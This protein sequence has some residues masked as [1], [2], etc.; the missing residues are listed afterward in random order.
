MRERSR[1]MV[2]DSL[3]ATTCAGWRNRVLETGKRPT[4][5]IPES[6]GKYGRYGV[7]AID[8]V[9]GPAVC[10]SACRELGRFAEPRSGHDSCQ[11]V[12]CR[13]VEPFFERFPS[14][15]AARQLGGHQF[16]ARCVNPRSSFAP[17]TFADFGSCAHVSD[18]S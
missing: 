17:F 7:G 9:P 13:L 15:E 16:D 10:A 3:L 8:R 11:P 4:E 14:E 5:G 12:G 18:G 1:E 2:G 6:L